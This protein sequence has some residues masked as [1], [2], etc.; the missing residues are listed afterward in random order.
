MRNEKEIERGFC[1]EANRNPRGKETEPPKLPMSTISK[2]CFVSLGEARRSHRRFV[3]CYESTL[4]KLDR[5]RQKNKKKK[6]GRHRKEGK[7]HT[8]KRTWKQAF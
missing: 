4:L 3:S 8:M 5:E 1:T 6:N 2:T 7:R